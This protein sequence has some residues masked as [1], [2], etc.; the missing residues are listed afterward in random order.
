MEDLLKVGV[1][2]TTH[3]VRGEVKVFPT[4]DPERFLDLE[5]VILDA[6]REMKKLEIRNVKFFKKLVILK[7][8]GIDNIND[9]EI[10]TKCDLLVTRDNAVKCE[11]GEYFICDLI[12]LT[13]VTDE[14]N[15]LGKLTDVIETGANNVYEVTAPGGRVYYLPV[16][17]E[18][19]LA[20]DLDNKT[21]TVHVLKGL[22]DIN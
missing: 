14:G 11:P 18:C 5:Y 16:I 21:V 6:G 2:T 20:H 17:D 8:D 13:V 1:I 19:I 22:L 15:T 9:I 10:Y 4:T 12:G 7:F 3:G